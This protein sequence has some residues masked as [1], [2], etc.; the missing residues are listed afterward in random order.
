MTPQ[1]RYQV[2]VSS[3]YDD[4]RE[5]RQQATQA[6]LEAGCFPS[7]ME[8]FPASDDTQWQLIKRVI[9]E[10]DYY[11]VIVAGR[12]GSI[13][14]EGLSYT[15]MEYDYAVERGIPVLGFVRSDIG[16]IAF[17]KT[18][19]SEDGRSKLEAFRQKVMSRTCRKYSAAPEL[20]MAVL[21]SLMAEARV[22]PRTG[23]VRAD[24]ARSD[25]DVQRERKLSEEL[26]E[27]KQLIQVL[28]REIRDRAIL[29]DELPRDLL[30]QENDIC[31]LTVTLLDT[32]RRHV[33]E[34]V[35]L[36]WNEIFKVIGPAMYGYILRKRTGYGENGTYSFQDNLEEHI[37]AKLI[38]RAEKRKIKIESSQIDN[39]LF[40]FKELGLLMFAENTAEDGKIFRGVTLT[41]QGERRLTRLSVRRR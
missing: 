30:A 29:E 24:L 1:V 37:R 11:T 12:Y 35:G 2:F 38:D 41:E 28:D 5:E 9:E 22:R 39:C 26:E 15:E 17:D 23:W 40:Q 33:R 8:L 27:A 25:A 18:E 10:S 4:L 19:T 13:G 3:T 21:K 14:P 32:N 7:G 31:E 16:N 20:G 34:E 36:T 6:I